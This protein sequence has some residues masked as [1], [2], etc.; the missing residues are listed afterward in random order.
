MLLVKQKVADKVAK[1][2][3][4]STSPTDGGGAQLQAR[5]STLALA[6]KLNVQ[7][8]HFPIIQVDHGESSD[9]HR[10][11]EQ[12]LDFHPYYIEDEE[13]EEYV[14]VTV[15]G[16]LLALAFR[17]KSPEARY[18]ISNPHFFLDRFP[19]DVHK[20]RPRLRKMLLIPQAILE[21]EP[22]S[23]ALHL[24]V[25]QPK[26]VGFTSARE[27][28]IAS[29]SHKLRELSIATRKKLT[30]FYSP[31]SQPPNL[32]HLPEFEI[33][34]SDALLTLFR[35][36]KSE[37]LFLAKSSLSYVAGLL[38]ENNVYYARFWHP[39]MPDWHILDL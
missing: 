10:R 8:V 15:V 5:I 36:V 27:T 18:R 14:T 37:N 29:I 11:W 21:E 39:P 25:F 17:R 26:D 24:R 13:R 19:S 6:L 30:V 20:I 22:K 1:L 3:S 28:D 33:D 7:Y 35:L 34:N 12:V 31:A 2:T 38:S 16:C 4:F 32:Q 9:W 23:L